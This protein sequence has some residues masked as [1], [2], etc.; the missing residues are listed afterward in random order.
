M[1]KCKGKSLQ[2]VYLCVAPVNVNFGAKSVITYAFLDQGFTHSFCGKALEDALDLRGDANDFTHQTFT[3]TKAHSGINVSLL[4]FLQNDD[5]NFVLPALYSVSE[6]PILPNPVASKIDL[7][8]FSHLKD[9][10]FPHIPGATV[11]LLIGADNPEIFCARNV[12]VN[13]KGQP[14]AVETPLG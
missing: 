1:Y 13:C 3:G 2:N 14:I 11:T 5:E 9:I 10:S 6:V 7:D 4:V 12:R 8:R